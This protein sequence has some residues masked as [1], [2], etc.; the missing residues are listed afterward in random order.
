MA[1]KNERSPMW[2]VIGTPEKDNQKKVCWVAYFDDK[3]AYWEEHKA[4]Q[5]N[6]VSKRADF[7]KAC[8]EHGLDVNFPVNMAG[9]VMGRLLHLEN[10]S[11][12][13]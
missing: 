13:T 4:A 10:S 8:K 5:E 7:T 2:S 12:T 1:D 9:S 6:P 3:K 11:C